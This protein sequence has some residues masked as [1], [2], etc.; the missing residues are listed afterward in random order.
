M[1]VLTLFCFLLLFVPYVVPLPNGE[2]E[3]RSVADIDRE[4]MVA[5]QNR[6]DFT[7]TFARPL[8]HVNRQKEKPA[9]QRKQ[10]APVVRVAKLP[11]LLI[12]VVGA[13]SSN[14]TAY[15]Q[16]ENT[17]ETLSVKEGQVLG[18]WKV[19]KI[20]QSSVTFVNG[21]IRKVVE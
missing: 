15:I 1:L 11:F 20:R 2:N 18:V 19:E 8:F 10:V 5:E 17:Q 12:G 7:K 16:N 9:L 4:S 3:S 14:L 21:N 13:D 6:S